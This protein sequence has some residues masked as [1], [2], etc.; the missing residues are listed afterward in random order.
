MLEQPELP[1]KTRTIQWK[2]STNKQLFGRSTSDRNINDIKQFDK[3]N[4]AKSNSLAAMNTRLSGSQYI[5][6][7]PIN[8]NEAQDE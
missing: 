1:K 2:G 7:L 3:N 4:Q 8:S 5:K 6:R